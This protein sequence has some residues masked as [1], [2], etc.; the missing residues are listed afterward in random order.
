M[1]R[2]AATLA[3]LLADAFRARGSVL[4]AFSGGVDSA[5]LAKVGAD[6]LG[7]RSLAVI[8]DSESYAAE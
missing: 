4:V 7:A 8:V 2:D 6:A 5:V 3:A 1:P